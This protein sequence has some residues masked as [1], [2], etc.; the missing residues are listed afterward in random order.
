MPGGARPAG[1]RL[2]ASRASRM[3]RPAGFLPCLVL[4]TWVR[5]IG[6]APE[7]SGPGL[8]R[9]PETVLP[10]DFL[11]LLFGTWA[12]ATIPGLPPE[13]IQRHTVGAAGVAALTEGHQFFHLIRTVCERY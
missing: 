1:R 12:G 13:E 5:H 6:G 8:Y 9:D 3:C 4:G 7:M 10:G 11:P 2:S